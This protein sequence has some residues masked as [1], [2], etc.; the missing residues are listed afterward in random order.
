MSGGVD[1]SVAAALLNRQGY[2]V[3]GLTLQL[4]DYEKI[5]RKSENSRGCCDITHQHDARMVC[6]QIG[7][8]HQV[9]DL[10]QDFLDK[11][12]LPYET[13]YLKGETP[14]PCV[15]CNSKIKW[16]SVIRK[17]SS[18][19]TDFISTGHYAR[20]IRGKN[21]IR[22]EKGIDLT[23]DQ[24]YALWQ[25]PMEALKKTILPLGK[26]RKKEIRKLAVEL[27]LRTADKSESQEVCFID[28]HYGTYLKDKYRE[29]ISKIGNGNIIN[30]LGDVVGKHGGFFNFTIGQRRG[31]DISDGHG[32][33]YVN[34]VDPVTN[35]ITIG[36][37]KD[38]ETDGCLVKKVNWIS[39]E[40]AQSFSNCTAK[41]RYNDRG[42]P[43]EVINLNNGDVFLRFQ[44]PLRAV[45]PGQ[46]AVWYRGKAVWGGGIISKGLQKSEFEKILTAA[47]KV[48]N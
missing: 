31:L 1:S 29:I 16:D 2:E 19:G 46:S 35:T 44:K 39:Y 9:M 20:I 23:K 41:I 47:G 3:L 24:S 34:K 17:V 8:P 10:R 14:N 37:L 32:P 11:V 30:G 40:P 6:D 38:L 18:L 15:S 42:A 21:G 33:Y 48:S 28:D 43:A 45:T 5:E 4:W 22:L 12:V 25:V 13:T 27:K 7:I 26:W 36:N